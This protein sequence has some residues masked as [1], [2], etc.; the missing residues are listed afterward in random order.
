MWWE[1]I[2]QQYPLASK[3]SERDKVFLMLKKMMNGNWPKISKEDIL[4]NENLFFKVTSLETAK[5]EVT[6]NFN[7]ESPRYLIDKN[8]QM[9]GIV[10]AKGVIISNVLNYEANE[11]TAYRLGARKLLPE[12]EK[13]SIVANRLFEINELLANLKYRQIKKTCWA[14]GS[15]GT[16]IWDFSNNERKPKDKM[17]DAASFLFLM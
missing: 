12:K 6:D 3:S 4:K 16:V 11:L 2:L 13:L 8:Y 1:P 7:F 17:K 5:S 10:V 14:T 9:L 15:Q